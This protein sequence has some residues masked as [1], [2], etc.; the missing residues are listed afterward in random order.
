MPQDGRKSESQAH[1]EQSKYNETQM[2]ASY[3][4]AEFSLATLK[5]VF[6]LI[7]KRA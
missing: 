3:V 4:N 6:F 7:G 2:S 5:Y 1:I